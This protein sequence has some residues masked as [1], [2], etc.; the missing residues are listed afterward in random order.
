MKLGV[1]GI[2]RMEGKL[3]IR[4]FFNRN[5]WVIQAYAGDLLVSEN[6]Y[7]DDAE[8][9]FFYDNYKEQK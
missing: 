7:Q 4:L 9:K 2:F 8:A 1:K 3:L 5:V 6:S